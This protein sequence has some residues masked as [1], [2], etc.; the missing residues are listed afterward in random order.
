MTLIF[1]A[2][3]QVAIKHVEQHAMQE[4]TPSLMGIPCGL[5]CVKSTVFKPVYNVSETT[6][7]KRNTPAS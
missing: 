4:G 7:T 2:A 6:Q 3:Q 1:T 5:T